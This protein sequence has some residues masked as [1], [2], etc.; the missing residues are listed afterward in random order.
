[1]LIFSGMAAFIVWL[2]GRKDAARDPALTTLVLGLLASFPFLAWIM[3]K[4]APAPTP[5]WLGESG[6]I[7]WQFWLMIGWGI[8]CVVKLSRLIFAAIGISKWRKRS[9]LIGTAGPVEIR[10]LE[11]LRGPVA[12]GVFRKMIFVPLDWSSWRDENRNMVIDHELEHHRR[13]DPLRRW[14]AEIAIAVNWF[15]PLVRW[16]MRRL[17]IQC[18]FACDA[19]VLKS[20]ISADR[21]ARMLCDLAETRSVREPVFA[22][23]EKSGLEMRV[24]HLMGAT[25]GYNRFHLLLMTAG[26]LLAAFFL[27]VTGSESREVFT[28]HEVETRWS[29]KAFPDE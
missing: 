16:I 9:M 6:G 3:P 23:A 20:G 21:Y 22:I 10:S 25:T 5:V 17:L 19:A 15:N 24:R 12:A 2:A 26:V 8:G 29:A 18:E 11:N 13:H 14:I 4:M 27:S 7:E 28:S 1:M